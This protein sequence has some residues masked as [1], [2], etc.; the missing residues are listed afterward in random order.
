MT[1]EQLCAALKQGN[2]SALD[3]LIEQN[4]AFLLHTANSMANQYRCPQHTDDLIQEGALGMMKAAAQYEPD[5]EAQFL[6]YAGYWVRKYMRSYLDAAIDEETVSLEEV[7][8]A[9]ED[10]GAEKLLTSYALSPENRV[11]QAESTKELYHALETL[12]ARERAY[13]WY[14]Y[15]FPD[16][17]QNKT[18]KDTASHFRLSES[19]AK[20]TEAK[21]LDNVQLELPWW[22]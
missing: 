3:T 17:D 16:E 15:G 22:Y 14:R 6:T 20:S 5:R 4:T 9:G 12:S 2:R 11:L 7:V 8:Q 13:L 1:N 10:A 19:R 21:A 18:L